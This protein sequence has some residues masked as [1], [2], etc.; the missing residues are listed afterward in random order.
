MRS[1]GKLLAVDVPGHPDDQ[2]VGIELLGAGIGE[3]PGNPPLPDG[4][5]DRL[6]VATGA[7]QAILQRPALGPKP[8]LNDLGPLERA[9]AIGEDRA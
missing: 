1:A 5:H 2:E 6:Q 7:R 3:R 8:P 4:L 9:H